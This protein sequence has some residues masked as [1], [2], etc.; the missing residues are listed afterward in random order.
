MVY[1]ENIPGPSSRPHTAPDWCWE[2]LAYRVAM[3]VTAVRL[4]RSAAGESAYPACPRCGVTLER[5]YQAFCD[6]CGQ[7]LD[8]EGFQDAAVIQSF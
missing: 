3:R 8:W 7:R 5:E 1:L 2:Q 6:R 4:F